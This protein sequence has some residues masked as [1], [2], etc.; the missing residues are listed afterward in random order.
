MKPVIY[1]IG[2]LRNPKIPEIGNIFRRKGIDA[3]D[4]WHAA[5]PHADDCWRDYETFIGHTYEQALRG[6]P[7]RHVF[8]FDQFHLN[9]AT[10]GILIL[11]AGKSGH[12]EISYLAGQKKPTWIL[13]DEV[14][15]RYDVMVQ[16]ATAGVSFSLPHLVEQVTK[17][18]FSTYLPSPDVH[19]TD[20]LWVA[21]LLEGEGSFTCDSMNGKSR[22][23]PRISLQMTDED[24]VKKVASILKCKVWGPYKKKE[25]R[26]PVWVCALTGMEA[27]AWMNLLKYYLG[28]RRKEQIDIALKNF[29]PEKYG[30]W[31]KMT[32]NFDKDRIEDLICAIHQLT[33]NG[34]M[35]NIQPEDVLQSWV[36]K[37][38]VKQEEPSPQLEFDFK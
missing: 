14:P 33:I 19:Q 29:K 9:R 24:V 35:I 1:L 8:D 7:A 25:P 6:H 32:S 20:A 27:A 34:A 13:F 38:I 28:S 37:Q 11:P 4:A 36:L 17:Y 10:G 26:K 30:K 3:F 12:L 21:G 16:F 2:S 22:P 15:E 23:R 18:D 31:R 5:G